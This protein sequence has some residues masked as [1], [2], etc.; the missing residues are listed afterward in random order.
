MFRKK[1]VSLRQRTY[2]LETLD[3]AFYI[4]ASTPTFLYF[5]LSLFNT[6]CVAHYYFIPLLVILDI[7]TNCET[8]PGHRKLQ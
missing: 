8:I 6:A 3:C 2:T 1:H 7:Y 4:G 5:N